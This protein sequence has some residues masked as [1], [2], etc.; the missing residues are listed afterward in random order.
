[1]PW[2]ANSNGGCS[3]IFMMFGTYLLVTYEPVGFEKICLK[4]RTSGKI[5]Q[6]S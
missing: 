4:L 5:D 3:Q 2:L 1:M 6:S